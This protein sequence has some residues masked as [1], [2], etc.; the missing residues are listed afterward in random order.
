MI[1]MMMIWKVWLA[2]TFCFSAGLHVVR[3]SGRSGV[4]TGGCTSCT[5]DHRIFLSMFLTVSLSV[6]LKTL[7]CDSLSNF[8]LCS[9]ASTRNQCIKF[10][11]AEPCCYVSAQ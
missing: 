1:M 10:P 5:E 9:Q 2:V 6:F 7:V 8:L 11:V 4:D 3:A